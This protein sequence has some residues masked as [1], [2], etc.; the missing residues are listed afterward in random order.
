[1][2]V[3]RLP[4]CDVVIADA[5]VSG[6]HFE[7]GPAPGGAQIVDLQS[8]NGTFVNGE[9]LTMPRVLTGGEEIGVGSQKIL[10]ERVVETVN[11]DMRLAVRV[12][13][14]SGK[15]VRISEAEA[16][17][18]GRG[19]DAVLRLSD[20][21]VSATHCRVV[22]V[23]PPAGACPHCGVPAEA[24]DAH[25]VGC[26]RQRIA[27]EVK[28]LGSANG[29]LVNG[30]PV[31]QHGRAD[32]LE[33]GEIQIGDTIIVFG[34]EADPVHVGPA[35]TVIR[36]IPKDLAAAGPAPVVPPAPTPARRVS[37][38]VWLLAGVAIV[39]IAI[40]AIVAVSK[41]GDGST[42]PPATAVAAV[43]DAAWVMQQEGKTTVQVFACDDSS[44]A[45][46]DATGSAGSGSVIDL[47]A[48]LILTNFHV[49]ANDSSSALM[50]QLAVAISI[51]GE[52]LKESSVVGFSACDDL[53]LL[54]V[55][56]DVSSF[57]LEQVEF[58]DPASIQIGEG[59]VV[60]GYPGTSAQTASGD[61]A[62]Q[63]TTGSVSALNGRI[64]NYVDLIQTDAPIN[65][66]NSGGPHV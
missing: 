48:G 56:D 2:V 65:P 15:G 13:V 12:G 66:G 5:L 3:G 59:V 43:H 45:R 18:I 32:L 42:T 29:V 7:I 62:L 38:V 40:V 46:C 39:A 26:G 16:V 51:T 58:A 1:M 52:D 35:P 8:S 10:V 44:E 6:Q 64:E 53:A 4:E 19:D 11:V 60:L 37:P 22:V 47:D 31:P 9:R 23:R 24:G 25:C 36:T 30:T 55:T 57:N 49:I 50:P 27:A 54:R 20:P 17:T 14:D 41:S 61:M 21:L 34:S 28:D 63:L 33:G